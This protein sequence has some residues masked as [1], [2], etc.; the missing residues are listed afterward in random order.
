MVKDVKGRRD[1]VFWHFNKSRKRRVKGDD[2][3]IASGE[4]VTRSSVAEE[5]VDWTIDMDAANCEVTQI[6]RLGRYLLEH[7]MTL[8]ERKK[9]SLLVHPGVG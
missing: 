1:W 9:L 5:E 6:R 8:P 2:N 3:D 4:K 7:I